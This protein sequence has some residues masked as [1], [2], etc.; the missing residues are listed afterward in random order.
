MLCGPDCFK[1]GADS[2]RFSG[3]QTVMGTA[4]MVEDRPEE[5]D[6]CPVRPGP[7]G[8]RRPSI[9]KRAK[10]PARRSAP[11]AAPDAD[12]AELSR[13]RAAAAARSRPNPSPSPKPISPWVVARG[14][15]RGRAAL[16]IGV[17]WMLGWPAV[18]PAS[19]PRL[20]RMRRD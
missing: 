12:R 13:S 5:M 17:G 16:V 18:Q 8:R 2:A 7:S 20:S 11:T 14:L 3:R 15:G 19:P 10:C 4:A 1:K 9:S 6:R